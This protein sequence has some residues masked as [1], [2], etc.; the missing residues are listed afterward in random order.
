MIHRLITIPLEPLD[1]QKELNTLKHIT[2]TNG[3][4]SSLIDK[5]HTKHEQIHKTSKNKTKT[6]Y[7]SILPKIITSTFQKL[8]RTI[9]S[10]SNQ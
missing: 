2:I 6:E 1:Y 8:N 3:F 7:G 5:L 4:K 10:L 9:N